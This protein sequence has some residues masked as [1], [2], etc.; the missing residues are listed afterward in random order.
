ME[1][2]IRVFF[3]IH[4]DIL[5]LCVLPV[6]AADPHN[7]IGHVDG[8]TAAGGEGRIGHIPG[9]Q[10]P[11]AVAVTRHIEGGIDREFDGNAVGAAAAHS[12]GIGV[13]RILVQ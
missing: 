13:A 3:D 1:I 10:T 8:N 11:I 6:E 12:G 7:D 9:R 5:N 2:I 4:A